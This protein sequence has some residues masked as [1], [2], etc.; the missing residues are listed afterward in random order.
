MICVF[1]EIFLLS[2]ALD[3]RKSP[4]KGV[5]G[6]P[7]NAGLQEGFRRKLWETVSILQS[8]FSLAL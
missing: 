8:Y 4:E 3:M 7:R 1:M 2:G 5:W 6:T